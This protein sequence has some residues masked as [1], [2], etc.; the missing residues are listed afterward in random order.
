MFCTGSVAPPPCATAIA[1]VNSVKSTSGVADGSPAPD[2][3]E[4][5]SSNDDHRQ[6]PEVEPA[7]LAERGVRQ[8]LPLQVIVATKVIS[9]TAA[10]PLPATAGSCVRPARLVA[11]STR[12]ATA[13]RPGPSGR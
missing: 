7:Q 10:R 9:P 11:V 13:G 1:V 12:R 4:R 8:L 2:L 3:R 6:R 5:N